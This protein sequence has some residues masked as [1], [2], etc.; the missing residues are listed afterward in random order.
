MTIDYTLGTAPI[1]VKGVISCNHPLTMLQPRCRQPLAAITRSVLPPSSSALASSSSSS[2]R[3]FNGSFKVEGK[4]HTFHERKILP[5][6]QRQLYSLVADTDSYYRFIPFVESSK[7]IEHQGPSKGGS[8][9]ATPKPW[10]DDSGKVG[11]V[12]R[13]EHLMKIGVMGF[14]EE[15]KSIVTC[16]KWSRVSVS[17]CKHIREA[18][19][20]RV[21]HVDRADR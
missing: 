17:A 10:L 19:R 4:L 18:D 5:Y 2:Q 3:R 13:M 1:T 6:T 9:N 7:V 20:S 15:W 11:D 8:S 12:H 14:D 16:E 21:V